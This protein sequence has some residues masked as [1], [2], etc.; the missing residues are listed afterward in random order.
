METS[1]I[2]YPQNME[3]S[4]TLQCEKGTV[5]IGGKSLDKIEYWEGPGKPDSFQPLKC[6]PKDKSVYGIGH[7]QVIKNFVDNLT[8]GKKLL[9]S[10]EDALYAIKIIEAAYKS[11]R[12]NKEVYL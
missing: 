6:T 10:G 11:A 1:T 12:T 2:S 8:R 5:K 3:G 7:E 4:I 9:C